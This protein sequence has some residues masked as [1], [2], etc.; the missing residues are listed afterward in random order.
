MTDQPQP[1]QESTEEQIVV[2]GPD[3]QPVGTIPASA[4]PAGLVGG[5][6]DDGDDEQEGERH[7]TELV[8]Q[9]AKVMR[10][11]SMIRQLLEEVKAAPLDEASRNRLKEIHQ[12]SIKE[13]E[14]G[15]APELVEEL[16]RLSLPFTEE[17]TPSESELRIAQ[18]QLV[19]WL[20]GLFHGIQTAIYAQQMAARG[21]LEQ[22]RKAL[23]GMA[24][25]QQGHHDPGPTP[26]GMPTMPT[27]DSPESGGSGGMYL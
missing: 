21:Q 10:I 15:L 26:Q 7:I 19:G 22:I 25:A 24:A 23:P 1:E 3:G 9:P 17:G 4:L 5:Q 6:G 11:G 14:A 27:Q 12:A 2:V 13:L 8:E 20:E 18:A 16:E